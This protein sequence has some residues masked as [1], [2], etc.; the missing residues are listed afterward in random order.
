MKNNS[1]YSITT[2]CGTNDKMFRI[3]G[4]WNYKYIDIIKNEGIKILLLSK[5]IGWQ[6]EDVSYLEQLPMI[7]DVHIYSDKLKSISVIEKLTWLKS[8]SLDCP[9]KSPFDPSKLQNLRKIFLIWRKG[10]EGFLSLDKLTDVRILGYPYEDLLP[11]QSSKRIKNLIIKSRKLTSLK[12]LESFHSLTQLELLMCLNLSNISGLISGTKLR[13]LE[14]HKCRGVSEL[15][16]V[17]AL[18]NLKELILEDCGELASIVPVTGCSNLEIL[19][20]AG[21]SYFLDGDLNS[22]RKLKNL[23]SLL[24][25]GKKHYNPKVSVLEEEFNENE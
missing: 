11:I 15:N 22:L 3:H 21:S 18:K 7:E 8:L 23:K 9:I 19:Q 1:D 10:F 5:H 2:R 17:S 6:E 20:I 24:L 12:G 4:N 13:R 16:P 14:L 25:V